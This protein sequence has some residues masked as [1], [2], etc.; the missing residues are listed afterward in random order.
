M[1]LDHYFLVKMFK[2]VLA[3]SFRMW[4]QKDKLKIYIYWPCQVLI[5]VRR[6][7]ELDEWSRR[8]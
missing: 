6:A 1:A 2:A 5:S 4:F 7:G 3:V 8:G